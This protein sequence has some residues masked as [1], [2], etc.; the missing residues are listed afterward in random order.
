MKTVLAGRGDC[1]GGSVKNF[2][3][4]PS[5]DSKS[6]SKAQRCCQSITLSTA[7]DA[8]PVFCLSIFLQHQWLVQNRL[9]ASL[10]VARPLV[11]SWP[12]K[13]QG[14]AHQPLEELRRYD[15]SAGNLMASVADV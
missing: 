8:F 15:T 11:S 14:R 3:E 4:Q 10:L 1:E 7:S 2:K 6:A 12:L 9:L 5:E 13:P